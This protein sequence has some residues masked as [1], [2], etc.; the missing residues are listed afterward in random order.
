MALKSRFTLC[1][2]RINISSEELRGAIIFTCEESV[3]S[4]E[5]YPE[6]YPS[7]YAK[8]RRVSLFGSGLIGPPWAP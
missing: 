7:G 3:S 4:L 8:S 1:H 5:S 6:S 2:E